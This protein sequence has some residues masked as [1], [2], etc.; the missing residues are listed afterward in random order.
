MH[1]LSSK[2]V[3]LWPEKPTASSPIAIAARTISS[4][5]PFPSQ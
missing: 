1:Q 3:R 2:A 5:V 4:G